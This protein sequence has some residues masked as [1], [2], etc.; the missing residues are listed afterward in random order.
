MLPQPRS[1]I[2]KQAKLPHSVVLSEPRHL[3]P[4]SPELLKATT[5]SNPIRSP[6]PLPPSISAGPPLGYDVLHSYELASDH[7]I[8]GEISTLPFPSG[9]SPQIQRVSELLPT[10]MWNDVLVSSLFE[11]AIAQKILSIL[12][13]LNPSSDL[14]F[15]TEW[16]FLSS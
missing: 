11:P 7:W 10:G 8:P 9:N 5:K 3:H 13:S 15:G 2:Q 12:L 6:F 1:Q 4:S 16:A 14:E